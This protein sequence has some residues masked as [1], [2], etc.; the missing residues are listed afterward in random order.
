MLGWNQ[1]PSGFEGLRYEIVLEAPSRWLLTVSGKAHSRYTT[2]SAAKVEAERLDRHRR[3][4]FKLVRLGVALG[5]VIALSGE[6]GWARIGPSPDRAAAETLVARVDTAY[7]AIEDDAA[8][9]DDFTG[10]S[11]DVRGAHVTLASGEELTVLLGEAAKE[12]YVLYWSPDRPRTTGV[13]DVSEGVPCDAG[14]A[15]RMWNL[16]WSQSG[17]SWGSILPAETQER[18]WFLPAVAVLFGVGL[19]LLIRFMIVLLTGRGR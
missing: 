18:A 4:N 9:A 2:A 5:I 19:S 6:V 12:C 10:T 16:D 11:T 15:I 8:S 3:R 1:T 17:A 13:L 14:V 7:R